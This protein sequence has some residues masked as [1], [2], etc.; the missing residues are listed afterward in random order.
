M[1]QKIWRKYPPDHI[2]ESWSIADAIQNNQT[3]VIGLMSNIYALLRFFDPNTCDEYELITLEELPAQMMALMFRP[4]YEYIHEIDSII[5]TRRHWYRRLIDENQVD[6]VCRLKLFP[7]TK[8]ELSQKPLD[9]LTLS[10]VMVAFVC[11]VGISFLAFLIEILWKCSAKPGK[12]HIYIDDYV[13]E[14]AYKEYV[15]LQN[16]IAHAKTE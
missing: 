10:G 4:R 1:M 12:R 15:I 8:Q 14:N 7:S 5:E 3:M 11:A 2:F 13:G 9:I 16:M 6:I